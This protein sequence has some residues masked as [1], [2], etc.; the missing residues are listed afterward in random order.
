MHARMQLYSTHIHSFAK[1]GPHTYHKL[2]Y[3]QIQYADIGCIF[4]AKKKKLQTLKK[5][6]VNK[7]P[8][9]FMSII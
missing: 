4:V 3:T 2:H 8:T 1:T 9:Y 5:K 7:Q 6:N